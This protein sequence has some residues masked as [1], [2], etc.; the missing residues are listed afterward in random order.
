MQEHITF[1][2]LLGMVPEQHHCCCAASRD[3][4]CSHQSELGLGRQHWCD[5]EPCPG[6]GS[7]STGMLALAAWWRNTSPGSSS[8]SETCTPGWSNWEMEHITRELIFICNMFKAG[9]TAWQLIIIWNTHTLVMEHITWKLSSSSSETHTPG[10]SSWVMEHITCYFLI[11]KETHTC[12][13]KL[14]DG[15]HHLLLSHHQRNTHLHDQTGWQST[16]IHHS[17]PPIM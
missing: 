15:A 13:I 12:M 4:C 7:Q 1:P 10:C 17:F 5:A 9:H 6:T 14:G 3:C 2:P 11:I 8:S 16:C